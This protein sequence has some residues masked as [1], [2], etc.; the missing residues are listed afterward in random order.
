MY[1]AILVVVFLMSPAVFASGSGATSAPSMPMGS[2]QST[3]QELARDAYNDGVRLIHRADD[4]VADASAATDAAKRQKKQDRATEYYRKALGRFE[5]A[6]AQ[7]PSMYQAWNY[8]GYA[9]R[10]LGDY[11]AALDAYQQA[12][13]INPAYVE[14]IE[15]RGHAYLGLNRLDDAKDAYLS[16]FP[17]DRKLAAQLLT[18]MQA[19]VASHRLDGQGVEAAVLDEFAKWVNERGTIAGTTAA[20]TRD[21][22]ASGWR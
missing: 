13:S 16:L 8:L 17:V 6:V 11:S 7:D 15:Y 2:S 19:W 12:L 21:G 14:A 22:A 4:S 5:S 9:R 3:P 10:H 1:R 18:G 20:L